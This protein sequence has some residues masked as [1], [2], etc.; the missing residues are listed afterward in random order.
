M[1]KFDRLKELQRA[2]RT[3]SIKH[4]TDLHWKTTTKWLPLDTLPERR[5]M[6]PKATTPARFGNYLAKRWAEGHKSAL[7]EIPES[8]YR[9]PDMERAKAPA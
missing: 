3:A 2:G 6:A 9:T 5:A 1:V 4:E 8:L 7:G